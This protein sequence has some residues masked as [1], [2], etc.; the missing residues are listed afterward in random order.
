MR[1]SSIVTGLCVIAVGVQA[2]PA[3]T[4]Y[5][6]KPAST[7]KDNDHD[8]NPGGNPGGNPSGTP[9]GNPGEEC[10]TKTEFI[11]TGGGTVTQAVT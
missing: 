11:T 9:G 4:D 5:K 7:A 8:G 10:P 2:F 1:F 3:E 6:D